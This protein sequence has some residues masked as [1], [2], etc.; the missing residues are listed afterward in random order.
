MKVRTGA[1]TNYKQKKRADLTAD[2]KKNAKK[3]TYAVLKKGTSVTCQ[4]VITLKNGNVWMKIPSGYVCA[5]GQKK[6]YI[7]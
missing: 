1:G 5:K 4:K 2:G 6:T 3:G 7:K